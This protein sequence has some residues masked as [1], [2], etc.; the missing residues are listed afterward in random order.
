MTNSPKV[1]IELTQRQ[2]VLVRVA[3]IRRL[4]HLKDQLPKR[5]DSYDETR[6]M[7]VDGGP[8]L[9]KRGV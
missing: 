6:A 8:L 4:D 7:L 5:Q 9:P 2:L 1:T 3:C